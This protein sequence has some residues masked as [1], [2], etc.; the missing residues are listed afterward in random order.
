MSK[1][2]PGPWHEDGT[3]EFGD[4]AIIPVKGGMAVA[5]VVTNG[6]LKEVAEANAHLIAAAPDLYETLKA[7]RNLAQ[8]C[9]ADELRGFDEIAVMAEAALAR[10]EGKEG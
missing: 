10:V 9:P 1:H 5:V 6:Q 3:D 2:T 4:K 7:I 8:R